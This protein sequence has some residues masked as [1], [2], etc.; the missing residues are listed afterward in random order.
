MFKYFWKYQFK[1]KFGKDKWWLS[2]WINYKHQTTTLNKCTTTHLYHF[3][4]LGIILAI[5]ADFRKALAANFFLA[6]ICC[7]SRYPLE[8]NFILLYSIV[9]L[10]SFF[11]F[12]IIVVKC[13]F[14]QKDSYVLFSIVR[15][16]HSPASLH[17]NGKV[18]CFLSKHRIAF[19]DRKKKR[20][21]TRK[22]KWIK[23]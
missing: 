13:F 5:K 21:K 17:Y 16:C 19:I 14:A 12:P 4:K 9:P 23:A 11:F 18:I 7:L 2:S 3:P 15:K 6:L 22:K 10:D 20:K 8:A 1:Q